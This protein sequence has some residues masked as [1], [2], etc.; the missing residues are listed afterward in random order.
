MS[1]PPPTLND[2]LHAST[3]PHSNPVARRVLILFLDGIGLGEDDPSFNPFA[4]AHTPTLWQLAGGSKW[5][6]STPYTVSER[7]IFI[8][9]DPRLGV[10]GRPQ[11]GTNQAVILT[12][13]NVP[14]EVGEHFGP[15]PNEATRAIIREGSLFKTIRAAGLTASVLDGY[16][17]GFFAG[18][19]S[20]KRLPSSIQQAALE[21]GVPLP[22]ESDVRL[23]EALS[24]DWT[25]EAWRD[26]LGYADVPV[27]TPEN[28]GI[29]LGELA[30]KTHLSFFS[31]WVTDEVGHRGPLERGVAL[32]ELF[33]RV[34]SGL[35][36]TWRDED[37]M[38]LIISDH[39]NMEDLRIRQH[40]L[41]NTPTV[42][43][44]GGT[45]ARATF[46]EGFTSLLDITP[47][48]SAYL[49]RGG[50]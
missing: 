47:K 14:L 7:A 45:E 17:P 36:S 6:N 1:N 42:I 19:E 28:A 4:A 25:G 12:G 50:V 24:V 22:T 30:R 20:G 8:P 13:R 10:P 26:Y 21:A 5:L 32:L 2:P 49:L 15:K 38:I 34:M 37:G 35:L 48:V 43:I 23:G 31:H 39:G 40:T 11:S 33:D 9:T 29:K 16:P 46:A 3:I 18:I 27:F 41:A 44:G